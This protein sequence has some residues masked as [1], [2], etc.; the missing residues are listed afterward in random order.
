[1]VSLEEECMLFTLI[2]V[3]EVKNVMDTDQFVIAK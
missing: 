3:E 1:M 2:I